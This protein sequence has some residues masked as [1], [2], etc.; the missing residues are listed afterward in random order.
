[1]S[2]LDDLLAAPT[3][4]TSPASAPISGLQAPVNGPAAGYDIMKES[5]VS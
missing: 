4:A 2:L 5:R 1:M 3:G